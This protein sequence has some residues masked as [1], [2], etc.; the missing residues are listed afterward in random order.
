MTSIGAIA[1]TSYSDE[2][3][4]ERAASA[5]IDDWE[6]YTFDRYGGGAEGSWVYTLMPYFCDRV[7]H[8]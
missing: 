7:V 2:R 4:N 3:T 5:E 8:A 1:D 6:Q